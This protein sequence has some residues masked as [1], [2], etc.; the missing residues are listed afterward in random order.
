MP[1]VS[2]KLESGFNVSEKKEPTNGNID[3]FPRLK[4]SLVESRVIG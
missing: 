1:V 4:I 3:L 2:I